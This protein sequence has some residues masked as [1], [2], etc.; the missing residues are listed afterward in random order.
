MW[1]ESFET[2][3]GVASQNTQVKWAKMGMW[4]TGDMVVSIPEESPAWD[5]GGQFD[6]VI[7]LNGLDGFSDVF[8]HGATTERLRLPINQVERVFWF[9][10]DKVTI[11]DGGIPV[12]DANGRMSWPDGGEPPIGTQYTITGD[13]FSE[14]YM[15][16][17]FPS[18]RNEHQGMRL[19]K[20]IVLRKFD[21]FGRVSRTP[22]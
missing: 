18:D 1:D 13:I 14:Y 17:A 15:L 21:L 11:V 16:D 9:A 12:F 2:V 5:I 4:E 8:T 7:T 22:V 20:R 6:R 3:V 10:A 19:P